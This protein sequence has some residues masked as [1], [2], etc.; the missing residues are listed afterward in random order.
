MKATPTLLCIPD[1]SGFTEFMSGTDFDLSS[2]VIPTLLNKIIYSNKI[3]LKVSEIEGDAVLFFK[4]GKMPP[5]KKLIEQCESFYLE[6]YE[7]LV[8]LREQFKEDKDAPVIP[9]VLGLKIILHFGE[10]VAATKVGNRIKLFGEDLIIAHRLLK[11]K[12]RMDE[13]ILLSE[14]LTKYYEEHD[15]DTEF[16]WG[17]LKKNHNEYDHVGKIHYHYINL[18]PLVKK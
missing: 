10:E 7:Q 12:I 16:D 8:V 6:F 11:N 9:E 3:G 13:Y 2:K 15:L 4:T 1:I 5:L 14:G 17:V 18:K